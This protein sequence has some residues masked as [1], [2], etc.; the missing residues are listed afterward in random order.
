MVIVASIYLRF[1][2]EG[3]VGVGTFLLTPTPTPPN[4]PSN[5]DFTALAKALRT[6][7]IVFITSG[8]KDFKYPVSVFT[9]AYIFICSKKENASDTVSSKF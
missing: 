3:G 6:D 9:C 4:I 5:S 7:H 2:I 1:Y 8:A